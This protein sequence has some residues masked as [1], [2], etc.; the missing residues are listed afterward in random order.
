[1]QR[2]ALRY[3]LKRDVIALDTRNNAVKIKKGTRYWVDE[4][5]L[6]QRKVILYQ[7]AESFGSKRRYKDCIR[8][9]RK[10]LEEYFEELPKEKIVV[11]EKPESMKLADSVDYIIEEMKKKGAYDD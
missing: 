6:H 8:M 9:D 5:N 10:N 7:H 4:D 11:N 1:M 3:R 2:V